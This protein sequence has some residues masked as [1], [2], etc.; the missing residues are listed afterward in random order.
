MISCLSSTCRRRL[1]LRA[2]LMTLLTVSG[3]QGP[4]RSWRRDDPA[5]RD[6]VVT[7][8]PWDPSSPTAQ[9]SLPSRS[10]LANSKSGRANPYSATDEASLA[11]SNSKDQR[12]FDPSDDVGEANAEDEPTVAVEDAE[13][14]SVISQADPAHR[15]ML[16][17][18]YQAMQARR[19]AAASGEMA[20]DDREL[21]NREPNDENQETLASDTYDQPVQD[22]DPRSIDPRSIDPRTVDPR[23]RM[24]Q[25]SATKQSSNHNE[26]SPAVYNSANSQHPV[27]PTSATRSTEAIDDLGN[28]D[29]G[30]RHTP[31]RSTPVHYSLNDDS[32]VTVSEE[33]EQGQPAARRSAKN[34]SSRSNPQPLELKPP[35]KSRVAQNNLQDPMADTGYEEHLPSLKPARGSTAEKHRDDATSIETITSSRKQ[36]RAQRS[37]SQSNSQSDDSDIDAHYTDQGD[38]VPASAESSINS[39]PTVQPASTRPSSRS[40]A[41]NQSNSA[42]ES[43]TVSAA[44]AMDGSK[45]NGNEDWRELAQKTLRSLE[46]EPIDGSAN[47]QLNHHVTK[48]ILFVLLGQLEQALEPIPGLQPH[49]QEYFR[50]SFQALY[51]SI[52][53]RGNPVLSRRW[54]LVLEDSRTAMSHLGAVSNLE[55]KNAAFCSNV[56][57]F[58][59]ITKF[60]TTQFKPN[61]EI[62]LYCEVDNFVSE[63]IKDGYETKLRGSYEI[64]D[65]NQTRVADTLL[66]EE[67]DICKRP[68]RDYFFVYRIY[69][70]QN[71]A[72]GRYQL[73]LTIEDVKGSKFGQTTLD[74][75]IGS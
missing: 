41:R 13:F 68:R 71:I 60:P 35:T 39:E 45:G 12:R 18:I 58:G 26:V 20:D 48:R 25:R 32:D 44:N 66:P 70:P 9:D 42:A 55:V 19:Q 8:H 53:P 31:P 17:Q 22:N 3:C 72:P 59:V 67:V 34:G 15:A 14:K 43:S 36:N 47:S 40:A 27:R 24:A 29:L 56:D 75:Q 64:V 61:Q 74:L 1:A 38:V 30:N 57:G 28:R 23:A 2:A 7:P 4:L 6:L 33:V 65:S 37:A 63:Q 54:P 10:R 21:G 52:D 16:V 46:Q 50:H 69:T 11:R 62:L 73:R 5:A 49:E 51:N